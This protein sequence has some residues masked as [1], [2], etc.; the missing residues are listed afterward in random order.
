MKYVG[1]PALAINSE[2]LSNETVHAYVHRDVAPDHGF[3]YGVRH[4]PPIARGRG[5]EPHERCPP[6]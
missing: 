3:A 1:A 5:R 6:V 4:A 2:Q